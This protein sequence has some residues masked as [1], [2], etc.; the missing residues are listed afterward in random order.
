MP[1][2]VISNGKGLVQSSGGG[3]A[4]FNAT[5]SVAAAASGANAPIA[6]TTSLALCTSG[7]NA[8]EVDLPAI[9]GLDVGHTLMIA[10]IGAADCV[11][12]TPGAETINGAAT[13]TTGQATMVVVV[14]SAAATWV[15]VNVGV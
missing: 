1:K 9:A 7:D 2:V 3:V 6:A 8:H 12:N 10:S 5:E 13:I 15:A 11:I 14:K 4:L